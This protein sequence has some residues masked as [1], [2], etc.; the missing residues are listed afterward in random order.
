MVRTARG[1]LVPIAAVLAL[2]VSASTATRA[3]D[4]A[5]DKAR[6]EGIVRDY[7]LEHPEIILEALQRLD[8]R[9]KAEQAAATQA[10][11]RAERAALA[12]DGYSFVAGNAAGDITLVEFYDY[13]CGYCRRVSGDL[14]ALLKQDKGLRLVFKEWPIR[15]DAS[16]GA[17][18]VSVAAAKQAKFADFH[19]ALMALE[20]QIDEARALQV[21]GQAGLDLKA[22]ARDMKAPDVDAILARNHALAERIGIDGTPAFVIGGTLIPG[23][24]PLAELKDAIASARQSCKADKALC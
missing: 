12:D 5:S 11:I 8:A 17:A 21:A 24:L 15:G 14:K 13:N 4:P 22:L 16:L 10:A 9:E 7:I 20:G 3:A 23:A 6:I 19:F 2:G 18:R 1:L